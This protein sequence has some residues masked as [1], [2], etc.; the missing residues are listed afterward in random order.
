[1]N[2]RLF[3]SDKHQI[4]LGKDLIYN[5]RNISIETNSLIKKWVNNDGETFFIIGK[6]HFKR[7]DKDISK[8]II[9]YTLIEKPEN[10]K[11]FEGR[12]IV[13]KV[14]KNN[15]IKIWN[16]HF[17]R[18]D[19]YWLYSKRENLLCVTSSINLMPDTIDLGELDQISLSQMLTIYGSRPLK[20]QTLYDKINRLGVNESL[21]FSNYNLSIKK[22]E[23]SPH[24]VFS[25]NDFS[26]L[27]DYSDR[28]IESVRLRASDTQNIVF[29]SSGWDSTSILAIL[30]HLFGPSK[31][32]CIIGK[33]HY[34]ERSGIINQFELDRAKKMAEYFKVRLHEVDLDYTIDINDTINELKEIFQGHGFGNV[35][36]FNHYLLTKGAKNR[37]L[38]IK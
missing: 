29:L 10:T 35:T 16:D 19:L 9:D 8:T 23:F 20:K 31:I 33:M 2:F 21:S 4:K 14:Y 25:K 28:L 12:Y 5:E 34:S 11:Y 24:S 18:L 26:K 27:D 30:V 1:M 15:E 38:A 6:I 3:T 37:C 22:T 36:G 17:S 7:E 13:L 32:D